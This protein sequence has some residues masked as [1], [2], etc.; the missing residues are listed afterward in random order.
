MPTIDDRSLA[1]QSTMITPQPRVARSARRDGGA[2]SDDGWFRALT[3]LM[4]KII[5]P[6]ISKDPWPRVE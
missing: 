4:I 5:E 2:R 1:I 3:I 6:C